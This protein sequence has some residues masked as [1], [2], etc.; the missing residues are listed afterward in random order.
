MD[1]HGSI[2]VPDTARVLAMFEGLV[3]LDP[4]GKVVN[5]LAELLEAN[6][7]ATEWTIRLKPGLKFHNG[8][9]VTAEDVAFSYRRV[10]NPDAPFAGASGLKP[11]DLANLKVMDERTIRFPAFAPYAAFPDLI[12]AS[13]MYSIVPMGYDPKNRWE[14]VPSNTRSSRL[15][16]RAFS[17]ALT[18]IGAKA[19]R[20]SISITRPFGGSFADD[21]SFQCAPGRRDRCVRIRS[22][23]P[24]QS[25]GRRRSGQEARLEAGPMAPPS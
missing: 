25:G 20:I 23:R 22:A 18:A 6:A 9:A 8:N 11:L 13:H 14:P 7:N 24:G 19:S 4:D 1:A 12:S 2:S 3:Q 5:A 17:C 16:S 10:A 21:R 15:A